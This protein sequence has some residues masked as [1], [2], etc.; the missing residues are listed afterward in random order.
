MCGS[1]VNPQDSHWLYGTQ[2]KAVAIGATAHNEG[3]TV[4]ETKVEDGIVSLKMS[5]WP[6]AQEALN[7]FREC[8]W[9]TKMGD[10]DM[11]QWI[12]VRSAK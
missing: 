5:S 3:E 6:R 11:G 1:L 8:G 9:A 2:A 12:H 10:N 7:A 4:L